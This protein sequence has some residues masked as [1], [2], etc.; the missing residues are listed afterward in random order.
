MTPNN[1]DE[2][3][4][5][6]SISQYCQDVDTLKRKSVRISP[7]PPRASAHPS[8]LAAVQPKY[9]RSVSDRQQI[10]PF[11]GVSFDPIEL[12]RLPQ[13]RT[14]DL[15]A[16]HIVHN[17]EDMVPIDELDTTPPVTRSQ[18]LSESQRTVYESVSQMDTLPISAVQRKQGEGYSPIKT[19]PLGELPYDVRQM[20]QMRKFSLERYVDDV[21]WW[22]LFPGRLEFLLWLIGAITLVC[23][24]SFFLLIIAT[25][26]FK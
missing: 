16:E 26:W 15:L 10:T 5:D 8:A 9:P 13:R 23:L 24:T 7:I 18:P 21:R 2:S 20:A 17:T 3:E 22:L 12:T 4:H 6:E 11:D 1:Q 19:R 25:I 14:T